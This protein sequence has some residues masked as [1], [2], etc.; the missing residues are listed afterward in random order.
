MAMDDADSQPVMSGDA[1]VSTFG[2]GQVVCTDEENKNYLT[3]SG[4]HNYVISA[5]FDSD[6]SKKPVSVRSK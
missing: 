4:D 1:D 6:T 5:E 3:Y 2:S